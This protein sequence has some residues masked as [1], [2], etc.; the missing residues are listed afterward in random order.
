M[1]ENAEVITQTVFDFTQPNTSLAAW[2]ALDDVVMGGVSEGRFLRSAQEDLECALFIGNV[3]TNN[4][5]GFSSVRSQNFEPPYRFGGWDGLR[6]NVKGDGQRYKFILRNSAGWDSPGYIYGLDTVADE[7]I[8]VAIPFNQMVPTFR[9]KSMPNAPAFD[10]ARVSSFQL[11]LSKFEYD[12][13]LNPQFQ[14]GPFKLAIATI[15]AY[16]KRQGVPLIVVGANDKAERDRQ[17]STLAE[18]GIH[19]RFIEPSGSSMSET[20]LVDAL[21]QA[22]S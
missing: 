21:S 3:S 5:G 2:G 19:Y 4:S 22:L 18:S 12:G 6:L 10:P 1:G 17:Q 13:R 9:A 11:M 15:S 7:W 14:P 20:A 16:R 8:E